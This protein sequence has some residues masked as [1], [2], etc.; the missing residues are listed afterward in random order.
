LQPTFRDIING[1]AS[2]DFNVTPRVAA[3]EFHIGSRE[4]T[5]NA[6]GSLMAVDSEDEAES[7]AK[8]IAGMMAYTGSLAFFAG[9]DPSEVVTELA[10]QTG[11][12][13]DQF[14]VKETLVDGTTL[15]HLNRSVKFI[16]S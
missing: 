6:S 16:L 14:G 15:H 10:N 2:A 7:R 1:L 12:D 11:L 4:L 9:K 13:Q 8:Q 5:S 3:R